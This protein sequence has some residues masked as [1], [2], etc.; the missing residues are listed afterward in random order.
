MMKLA[1]MMHVNTQMAKNNNALL[2]MAL[3]LCQYKAQ[4]LEIVAF[5][6]PLLPG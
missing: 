1:E 2:S 3:Y 5:D 4:N 6:I